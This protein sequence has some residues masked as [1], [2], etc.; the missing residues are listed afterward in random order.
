V[1]GFIRRSSPN[2]LIKEQSVRAIAIA[3]NV[4]LIG[5]VIYLVSTSDVPHGKDLAL[6][7]LFLAAPIASL[8]ALYFG[9]GDSWFSLFFK[10]KALEEK[11]KIERIK[12]QDA[13]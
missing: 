10:R 8:L 11:A 4:L 13:P 6:A 3:L 1:T 7:A 2:H 5:T 9:G 12:K